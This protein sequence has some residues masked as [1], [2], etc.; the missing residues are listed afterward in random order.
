MVMEM[1][2]KNREFLNTTRGEA[3]LCDKKKK[4]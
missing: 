1:R 2:F 4:S 3:D